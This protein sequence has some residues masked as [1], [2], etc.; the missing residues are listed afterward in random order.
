MS[1]RSIANMT[2]IVDDE[3]TTNNGNNPTAQLLLLNNGQDDDELRR[4]SIGSA[5]SLQNENRCGQLGLPDLGIRRVS[6]ISHINELR[7]GISGMEHLT[8]EFYEISRE[9]NPDCIS[10][11]SIHKRVLKRQGARTNTSLLSDLHLPT[12]ALWLSQLD[13]LSWESYTP[14]GT[15]TLDLVLMKHIDKEEI[16][17]DRKRK[18]LPSFLVFTY[19]IKK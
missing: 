5:S 19:T 10:L 1:N 18:Y 2:V 6:E 15:K 8:T 12:S 11:D 4:C 13:S 14:F 9:P 3:V 16:K 17:K 7:R